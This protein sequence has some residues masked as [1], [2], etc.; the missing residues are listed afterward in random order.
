[1]PAKGSGVSWARL[2]RTGFDFPALV[3][4]LGHEP[5]VTFRS[6]ASNSPSTLGRY[7]VATGSG[8]DAPAILGTA[9]S[10]PRTPDTPCV[11]RIIAVVTTSVR[12]GKRGRSFPSRGGRRVRHHF[13]R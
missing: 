4:Y 5:V 13:A 11:P 3:R 8:D 2:D 10:G 9:G 7:T 6:D 12:R 1:M